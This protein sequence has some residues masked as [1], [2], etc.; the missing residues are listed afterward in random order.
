MYKYAKEQ[1]RLFDR[2]TKSMPTC[3]A[4]NNEQVQMVNYGNKTSVWKCRKC[5]YKWVKKLA[6]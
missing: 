1:K 2:H 3:P 5:H 6:T 4:C